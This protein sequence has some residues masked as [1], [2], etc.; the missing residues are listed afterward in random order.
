[1][2]DDGKRAPA[3][4]YYPDKWMSHVEHLSDA[5]YRDYHQIINW[6]W[7]HSTT[8]Y[9]CPADPEAIAVVVLKRP[10]ERV[11]ASLAEIQNKYQP[12][13][14]EGDPDHPDML[15]SNGLR[16]EKLKQL[17]RRRTAKENAMARHHPDS[18][19][20][21]TPKSGATAS[22]KGDS[23][24]LSIGDGD[25]DGDS[26]IDSLRGGMK[27]GEAVAA[28][29]QCHPDFAGVPVAAIENT[30]KGHMKD[31][32]M[33]I[34]DEQA[35]AIN[36]MSLHYAGAQMRKPCGHLDNYL[37]GRQD[38]RKAKDYEKRKADEFGRAVANVHEQIAR[39]D[40]DQ[41]LSPEGRKALRSDLGRK[42]QD[43]Y[44]T[45]KQDGTGD[46]VWK[47]AMKALTPAGKGSE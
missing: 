41:T 29:K 21:K 7:L 46:T 5:A 17:A 25:G 14:I 15:V 12:L 11:Q 18:G 43:Q 45:L 8:Q 1:M 23:V 30:L 6:M 3:F 19:N 2:T 38:T 32:T 13:L 22:K 36:A 28:I 40:A 35:T 10:I 42:V 34:T 44:R 20:A 9:T 47:A 27:I 31:G 4:Q 33:T 26:C 16:K 24:M 37:T 39:L